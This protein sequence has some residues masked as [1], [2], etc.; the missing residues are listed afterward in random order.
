M[1]A[2]AGECRVSIFKIFLLD[3]C[4][5]DCSPSVFD[6]SGAHSQRSRADDGIDQPA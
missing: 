5:Q 1:R 3:S 2:I 6:R 4:V